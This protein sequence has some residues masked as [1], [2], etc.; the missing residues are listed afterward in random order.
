[1]VYSE[2]TSIL[3]TGATGFLGARVLTRLLEN[4]RYT[5]CATTTGEASRERL[6]QLSEAV[7]GI[8]LD[9]DGW[10]EEVCARQVELVLHFATK[11]GRR[12]ESDETI[13][14][15]IL[16]FP[17]ELVGAVTQRKRF[18]SF[19]NCDTALP[20]EVSRYAFFKKCWL[21]ELKKLAMV[22]SLQVNNVVVQTFYGAGDGKFVSRM[23]E[24]LDDGAG[25]IELTDGFQTRDFVHF[26]DVVS[27]FLTVIHASPTIDAGYTCWEVG[28]G[29]AISIRKLLE[30]LQAVTGNTTT[31][32]RWGAVSR[33]EHEPAELKADIAALRRWGWQPAVD[34]NTGLRREYDR[35]R[36]RR[37]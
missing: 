31:P 16:E 5:L 28:S 23:M 19:V 6:R 12:G 27:A 33:R 2:Q 14:R 30:K 9:R 25:E 7:V 21:Q 8:R 15:A 13:R 29:V 32:L 3:I 10:Q 18:V 4:E 22:G 34:L 1:M 11:Y 37:S 26:E 17:R 20:G 36:V 24:L 35:M